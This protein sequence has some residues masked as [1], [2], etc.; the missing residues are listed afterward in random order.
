M[1]LV[2][3]ARTNGRYCPI[4]MLVPSGSGPP[5][6]RHDFEEMFTIS[7]GEIELIFRGEV[8]RAAAGSTVNVPANAPH[9]VGNK[10]ERPARRIRMSAPAGREP[11]SRWS[12]IPSTAGPRRPPCSAKMNGPSASKRTGTRGEISNRA[13]TVRE[14]VPRARHSVA[15]M[16][17][18]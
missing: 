1:I 13:V 17:N 12:T 11:S 8:G 6:R 18:L 2:T 5:P 15:P 9:F 10:S 7:H 16:P 3:G 14:F 4:D